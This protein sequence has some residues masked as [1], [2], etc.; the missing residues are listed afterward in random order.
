MSDLTDR[1]NELANGEPSLE[2]QWENNP[3]PNKRE[4]AGTLIMESVS[5]TTWLYNSM[6]HNTTLEY[7]G[8]TVTIEQ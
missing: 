1:F 6:N 8:E 5:N 3:E 7:H 2:E 4:I